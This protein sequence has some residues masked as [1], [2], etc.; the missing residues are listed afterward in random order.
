[1][2]GGK[3]KNWTVSEGGWGGMGMFVVIWGR[4]WR[5]YLEAMVHCP[6]LG[7]LGEIRGRGHVVV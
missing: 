3:Q 1:M 2:E 5:G 7:S 4:P 6:E